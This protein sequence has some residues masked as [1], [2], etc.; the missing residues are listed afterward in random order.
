M[1]GLRYSEA[2]GSAVGAR[3][4]QQGSAGNVY[5]VTS[6]T[7]QSKQFKRRNMRRWEKQI[8][9]DHEELGCLAKKSKFYSQ[10]KQPVKL[11]RSKY[12]QEIRQQ[13][14]SG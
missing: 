1:T 12:F 7:W 2:R 5:K 13:Q 4:R 9:S 10:N 11:L 3:G 6:S 14:C 8:Q